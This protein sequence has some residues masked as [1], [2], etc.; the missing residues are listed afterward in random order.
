MSSLSVLFLQLTPLYQDSLSLLG[1]ERNL[2]RL[3]LP[4]ADPFL[5][6]LSGKE[7]S[8]I[9]LSG[10]QSSAI[11][12]RIRRKRKTEHPQRIFQRRITM[13]ALRLLAGVP[14]LVGALQPV[15]TQAKPQ[16]HV[17]SQP[18][19][20]C[21]LAHV[22]WVQV[23]V[24][25]LFVET[26]AR[27]RCADGARA[28]RWQRRPMISRSTTRVTAVLDIAIHERRW[29]LRNRRARTHGNVCI[30]RYFYMSS[31]KRRV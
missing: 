21:V 31:G 29:V 24:Q 26:G 6:R 18:T 8:T 4:A 23:C 14:L 1:V 22:C 12:R 20:S 7:S 2:T 11:V 25:C 28:L 15:S 5:P 17:L 10:K 19:I 16:S 27:R 9:V 30:S 13:V 3:P